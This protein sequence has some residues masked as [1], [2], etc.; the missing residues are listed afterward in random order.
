MPCKPWSAD[1]LLGAAKRLYKDKL[2]EWNSP[3][4]VQAMTMI[5]SGAEQVVCVLPTGAGKSLLSMLQCTLPD[6][7]TTVLVVLLVAPPGDLIR[8]MRELGIEYIEWLPGE[9]RD[10]SLV[11]VSVVQAFAPF[12]HEPGDFANFR[13]RGI[14]FGE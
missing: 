9:S 4:Q 13:R 12:Y 1:A 11:V 14:Y 6:A 10:A 3:K 8:R 2:L 5:M 7:G